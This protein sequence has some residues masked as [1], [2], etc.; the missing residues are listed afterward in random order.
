MDSARYTTRVIFVT[1]KTLEST[2][3]PCQWDQQRPY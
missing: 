1:V 2:A 3:L